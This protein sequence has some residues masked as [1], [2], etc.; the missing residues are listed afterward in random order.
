MDGQSA[1]NGQVTLDA[2]DAAIDAAVNID[3]SQAFV[4]RVRAR[5]AVEPEPSR[6]TFGAS[7]V[8]ATAFA[9]PLLI[10]LVTNI[11][12]RGPA[13]LVSRRTVPLAAAAIPRVSAIE[14]PLR[15]PART[16]A[17]A[18]RAPIAAEAS[19]PDRR[20]TGE[21]AALREL[22]DAVNGGRFT[23]LTPVATQT[24]NQ[25]ST[26]EDLSISPLTISSI[27]FESISP[28]Q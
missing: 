2:V 11:L 26:I 8:L 14:L 3:P 15:N 27:V 21:G 20:L 24:R 23:L 10:V 12:E 19:L 28:A 7:T 16:A 4:A 18:R 17:D 1:R 25:Q 6:W 22:I 13:P 9:V 5:I